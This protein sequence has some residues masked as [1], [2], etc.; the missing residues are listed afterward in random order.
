MFCQDL[1]TLREELLQ[2]KGIGPETADSMLLYAGNFPIFVVDAYTKRIFSRKK[3][4]DE[5]FDYQRLQEIFM[6]NLKKDVNLYNEYHALIV[7]LGKDVCK[8]NKPRCEICP[9]KN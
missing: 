5:K 4:V 2:V 8:K 9:I 1:N 7:R 3:I 6:Q